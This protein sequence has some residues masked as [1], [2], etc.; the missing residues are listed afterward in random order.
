MNEMV[1]EHYIEAGKIAAKVRKEAENRIKVDVP[2]LEIAE[3]VENRIRELGG[4]IAFPCNISL[5]EVASH[6]TPEDNIQHFRKGDIVKID[7]G[8]HVEGFIAD[9]AATV[10]VGE[11][12]RAKLIKACEEALENAIYSIRENVQT[13]AIGKVIEETIKK[14]GF[15]PVTDLTGHNLERYKLHAGVTIPNYSS[16]FSQKIKKDMVLAI[17]PFATSGRGNIKYGNPHIYAVRRGSKTKVTEKL[18]ERFGD[19]PF[20]R[21][22]I[23]EIRNDDLKGLREY[24]ELIEAGGEIVVQAEHT[25][26]VNER[27]CEVITI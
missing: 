3:Y 6:Y 16:F 18:R 21:R 23:P 11:R 22:W 13:K 20:A 26:I 17:E 27:G 4:N 12:N 5:N 2:L 19:L 9:T 24:A 10:E 15:N 1:H 14:S 8:V 7:V 25:V